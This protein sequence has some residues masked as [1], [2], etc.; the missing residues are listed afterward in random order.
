MEPS[1][2]AAAGASSPR[3]AMRVARWFRVFED[4]DD[5]APAFRA[6]QLQAVLA[7]TPG[8]MAINVANAL[9]I[10][11]TLWVDASHLFLG[12]WTLAICA[13]SAA[14][15]RGWL[16]SRRGP[17]RHAASARALRR[18]A[19]Q[20]GVLGAVWGA[21][22]VALFARLGHE[23]QFFVGMIVTGMICAGAFAL[24]TVPCAA[25]AYVGALGTGGALALA[26]WQGR[27]A[28]GMS[29]LL[30]AYA[31]MVTYAAWSY[32]K[33]FG[34]R[35]MAEAHA[36]HQNEV[37]ALLLRDFEDHASDLLWELDARGRFARVSGRL[38]AALGLPA[39]RLQRLRATLLLRRLRPADA[40]AQALWAALAA[41]LGR[42]A[43]FRDG[44]LT[45]RLREGPAWWMLSARPLSDRHG[46]FAGWRGVASDITD[47]H[48]AHRR[49]R[50]LAHND[51]LT[52]LANRTQFRELL[53]SLLPRDAGDEPVAV[54]A[55]DLDSFKQVNDTQGHAMGDEVLRAFGA[56]LQAVARRDDTVARL[57]GDE[58]AMLV[59]GASD[60]A[61]VRGLLERLLATLR[62]PAAGGAPTMRASV[63][64][65][66]APRDGTDVDQL[67]NH[68]DI[69]LYSAK[70]AGGGIYRVF[71]PVLAETGRQYTTREHALRGALARSE[72]F[73]VYQPLVA[74]DDGR[75]VGFEALLRWRH[76]E[77]GDVP[78][79]EFIAIAEAAHLMADIGG[80]VLAEACRQAMRW[81]AALT[82]SINVSATQL[83][84]AGFVDQVQAAIGA[85]RPERVELE[86][87]EST[88]V[89]DAE[90]AVVGLR[91]LRVR[92]FHVALDDFGT[93]YSALSYLRR[94]PFDT[95][96]IDRSF[97]HGVDANPGTE[98]I[99]DAILAL[100]RALGM[101]TVAEGVET[102]AELRLLRKKGC[103]AL[104]GYLIA[105]PMAAE[106]VAG[107]LRTWDGRGLVDQAGARR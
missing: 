80:W 81:P 28:I 43:P 44:L 93:G 2:N 33:T 98:V 35:L 49:L 92:G 18:A 40:E 106:D 79:A 21:L 100:G 72:F 38:A 25:T 39:A 1:P 4:E 71:D 59:R 76:P 47:R 50:W 37:I 90:H 42:R 31:A 46:S 13:M 75:L 65:A 12:L 3:A 7:V 89:A 91:A 66:F 96:K 85:L 86:I 77:L 67:L 14:G 9:V 83:A 68:A 41:L 54:L 6:R 74:A 103:D 70:R 15:L 48:L 22:P 17:P 20:A 29:L 69:A 23:D 26:Q 51:A 60:E 87:T 8:A 56:R 62:E 30:V 11:G 55:F 99:V 45:L 36:A 101:R 73:L 53:A 78:P 94:F 10:A 34:A 107:F 16:R 82:V 105:T 27:A 88:L 95:L 84:A 58:F 19:L 64:V 63:G 52:G 104:Q 57:G 32:A 102:G 61:A 97:V 5:D 24:S